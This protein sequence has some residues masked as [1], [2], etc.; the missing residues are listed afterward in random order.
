MP[1]NQ[2]T[3]FSFYQGWGSGLY[4]PT[5]SGSDIY[6]MH[7]MIRHFVHFVPDP[8][9]LTCNIRNFHKIR[10]RSRIQI[11]IKKLDHI[12][13]LKNLWVGSRSR[14]G[15]A[16]GSRSVENKNQSSALILQRSKEEKTKK[17]SFIYF[18][19]YKP[20]GKTGYVSLIYE[21]YGS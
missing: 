2:G 12:F 6:F 5:G 14:D 19:L 1:I 16:V 7:F 11:K 13:L 20:A 17:K 10:I 21:Y 15:S 4:L 8:W 18:Y 9:A 3:S